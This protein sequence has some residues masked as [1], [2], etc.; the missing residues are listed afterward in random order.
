MKYQNLKEAVDQAKRIVVIQA[1]N[2][3]GD[4]LGSALALEDIL[5]DLGKEVHLYCPVDIPKY[6]RYFRGWERIQ[7]SFDYQADLAIVVDTASS[8]LLSKVLDDQVIKNFLF[9]HPVVA[10]DHHLTET[11]LPF[12]HL[13]IA[14]SAVATCEI[15]LRIADDL[16]WRVDASAARNLLGGILSDTLGLTTDSVSAETFKMVA[17]LVELGAVPSEINSSRRELSKMTQE[18]LAYKAELI[19]KTDY[20]LDGRLA[21]VVVTFEEIQKYSDKYNPGILILDELRMVQGVDIAIVFKTYP[22]GK[23]TGK[24]RSDSPVA[25]EVAGY[26]GGGGHQFAA[27]FRT[28]GEFETVFADTLNVVEQALGRLQSGLEADY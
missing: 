13:L 15:I 11:D 20:H 22:D 21:T 1:E 25:E 4:S 19:E 7:D 14:E 27:G 8:V 16:G 6:L 26:F 9:S 17:E 12:D 24:I 2:P 23:I 18:I 10:I 3:D 28:Y 5:V